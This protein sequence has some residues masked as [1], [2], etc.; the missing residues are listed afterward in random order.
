MTDADQGKPVKKPASMTTVVAASTAGTAFEWYDFFLFVPLAAIMSRTFFS[1]LPET[2]AYIF[3]LGAF[4]VGFA[5]RPLGALI[6]G[7]I[8][9]RI[10][11]KATFLV[12]MLLMG[13]A[14]FCIGLIPSYAQIGVGAPLLFVL[15]RVLQGLALGG[16][17]GGAAIYIVEH[18]DREKRGVS[19]SWLGCSAAFGLAGAIIVVLIIRAIIGQDALAAWGWR[20]PFL[21]SSVLLAISIW[22][23]LK[24]HE[25]PVFAKLREEGT[26]SEKPYVESFLHWPN[27]RKVLLAFFGIMIAQGAVWFGVFFYGSTF[28]EIIK[29]APATKDAVLLALVAASVPLYVFFG[30]LSDRVG[31]K[32]VML[33]GMALYL[34]AVFPAFHMVTRAGNPDL[35]EA[36]RTAPVTVVADPADC[37]VQFDPVGKSQFSTSCDIAKSLLS[38]AGVSYASVDAPTG[39]VAQVRV[40]EAAVPSARGD[41]LDRAG[42]TALKG[43]VGTRLKGALAQAGY[44]Q[45]ADPEK[46]NPFALFGILLIVVVAATA[47]YGPQAAALVEMFPARVRYTALSF[48]YHLGTGWV[49]GLL[50][51]AAVAIVTTTGNIYSGLWY[52]FFFTAIAAAV[53]AIFFRETRGASLD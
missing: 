13:V 8:G 42:L 17:W 35:A 12:T 9:D 25:S 38:Q 43:E 28:M 6:F 50:P 26:R 5:F 23:R 51:A 3:A 16:E 15:M 36:V 20:I 21:F 46:T 24:L 41:G 30:W 22:I 4:A 19:S 40:G 18:V 48:P 11:R 33:F 7:R 53:F 39:A 10:G 32:P 44:P 14:T 31:R 2:T 27:L 37:S 1:G 45:A 34:A 47:L 49:G 29:V 52:P